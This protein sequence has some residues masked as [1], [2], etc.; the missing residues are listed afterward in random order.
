[1]NG[2]RPTLAQAQEALPDGTYVMREDGSIEDYAEKWADGFIVGRRPMR[3]V[4]FVPHVLFGVWTENGHRFIDK[5]AHVSS[6]REARRRG[7]Q[8]E[9]RAIYNLRTR[10]VVYL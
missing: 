10:E 2:A 8:W 9:Q 3:P 5:V 6:A 1:M 4:D 7:A